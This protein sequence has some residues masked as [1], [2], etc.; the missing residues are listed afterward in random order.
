[1][2]PPHLQGP[3]Y[4]GKGSI[5]EGSW[6]FNTV[7]LIEIGKGWVGKRININDSNVIS[8]HQNQQPWDD[9]SRIRLSDL[10]P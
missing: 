5:E 4:D 1:V 2:E 6:A 8:K 10:R 7:W 9:E 3:Q